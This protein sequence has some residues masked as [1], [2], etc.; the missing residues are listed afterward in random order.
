MH[1][2][3]LGM[4]FAGIDSSGHRIMGL[5]SAKGLATKVEIDRRYTWRVPETWSLEQAATIPVVYSTAYYALIIRGQLKHG[6]TV[7]VHAG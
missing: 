3:L 6:E 4:E 7:L 5:L 1:D 2:C